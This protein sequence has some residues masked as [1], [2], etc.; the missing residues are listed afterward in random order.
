VE[1][2]FLF[3]LDGTL[4]ESLPV[5]IEPVRAQIVELFSGRGY[6][7]PMR[8]LLAAIDTAA[9]AV[10]KNPAE[11]AALRRQ[12]RELVD[13]AELA[14]AV[15][16]R[17]RSGAHRV[18]RYAARGLP[19]AIVTDNGYACAR[20]AL[21]AAGLPALA[22]RATLITRDQ[23]DRPKPDPEGLLRAITALG[24]SPARTIVWVGDSV[25]D[26]EAGRA[27]A[28]RIVPRR[29]VAAGVLGG[30]SGAA[31]LAAAGATEILSDPSAALELR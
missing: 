22:A 11:R 20:A 13:R 28:R 18:D 31:E 10:G 12:A 7:G 27:A 26:M 5:E 25:R 30:R 3:D 9:A 1:P 4:V 6:S 17:P 15:N 2:F 21:L 8:P 16:A 29:L 14:A 24:G 23:V 19:L